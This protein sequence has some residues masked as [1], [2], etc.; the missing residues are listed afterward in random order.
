MSQMKKRIYFSE[1]AF[2]WLM[3]ATQPRQLSCNATLGEF[4]EN[5][6]KRELRE[7]IAH[8]QAKA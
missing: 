7:R 4:V 2:A 3:Q 1:D 5:E 8:L 6:T